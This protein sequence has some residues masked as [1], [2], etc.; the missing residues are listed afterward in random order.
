MTFVRFLFR[1]LAVTSLSA[2]VIM[3]VLDATRTI[4]ASS[5]V[6]TPLATS[7]AAVSPATLQGFEDVL[8]RK[9]GPLAWDPVAATLLGLP[10]FVVF[11]V[12][13]LIF[14]AIGRRPDEPAIGRA[15]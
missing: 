5:L 14:H 3:A 11:A 1:L 2:A 7:W 8:V 13:A 10:G 6:I 15:V 9:L 12:F 4:A